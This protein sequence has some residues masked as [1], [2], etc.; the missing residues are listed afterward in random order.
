MTYT[1]RNG[2]LPLRNLSSNEGKGNQDEAITFPFMEKTSWSSHF[3]G[4]NLE[5]FRAQANTVVAEHI[6]DLKTLVVK[7]NLLNE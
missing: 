5:E 2:F 1:F 3:Q 7:A 6:K 4:F